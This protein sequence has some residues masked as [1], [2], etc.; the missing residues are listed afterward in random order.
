M[1]ARPNPAAQALAAT[2]PQTCL[3]VRLYPAVLP[4]TFANSSPFS[5]A[6]DQG[7][8][9]TMFAGLNDGTSQVRIPT[10]TQMSAVLPE[11]TDMLGLSGPVLGLLVGCGIAVSRTRRRRQPRT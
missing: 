5:L 3:H 10:A 7:N 8:V 11:F 6:T 4:F 2:A 1:L 9:V